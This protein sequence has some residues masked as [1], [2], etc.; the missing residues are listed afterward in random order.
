MIKK[1]FSKI[2]SFKEDHVLRG[3]IFIK[4]FIKL[5]YLILSI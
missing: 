3:F 1:Y 5:Q 2:Q 4:K